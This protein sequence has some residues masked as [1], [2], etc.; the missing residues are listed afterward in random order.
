[1]SCLFENV[2]D[3]NGSY[4]KGGEIANMVKNVPFVVI[5]GVLQM[6]WLIRKNQDISIKR[7][8]CDFFRAVSS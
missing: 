5:S 2:F 1:M 3:I 6:N 7:S 8:W 4:E